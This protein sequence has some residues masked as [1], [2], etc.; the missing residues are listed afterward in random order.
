MQLNKIMSTIVCKKRER[1]EV[2][3]LDKDGPKLGV[4]LS[5]FTTLS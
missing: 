2:G 5:K 3:E 1:M 4:N